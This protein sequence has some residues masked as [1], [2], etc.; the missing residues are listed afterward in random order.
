VEAEAEVHLEGDG[1]LARSLHEATAAYAEAVNAALFGGSL[2]TDLLRAWRASRGTDL[3]LVC[4][5]GGTVAAHAAILA[6]RWPAL[7]TVSTLGLGAP[8]LR[9]ALEFV[10]SD[11]LDPYP[12]AQEAQ[13]LFHAAAMYSQPGLA[14]ADRHGLE[15]L[16]A[17]AAG[18]IARNAGN[19][20]KTQSWAELVQ[21]RPQLMRH[22]VASLEF[23]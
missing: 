22:I 4:A 13:G 14:L 9:R 10:Y 12:D 15:Q 6:S 11:A 2:G 17:R 3:C 16:R 7:P 5:D 23:S 1:L 19:V 18:F 20:L 8:L 21:H